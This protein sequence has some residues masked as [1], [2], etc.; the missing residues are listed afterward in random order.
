MVLNI[1]KIIHIISAI[2]W[3]AGLFYLPRIFVY[4]TYEDKGSKTS[5]TFKIMEHKL[6]SII[7]TPAMIS[8]WIMG[9]SMV[10]E[11]GLFFKYSFYIK[12]LSVILMTAYHYYL[13]YHLEQF[14]LD[15]NTKNH[16]YF[17]YLN[18]IPTVLIIVIITIVVLKP[19]NSIR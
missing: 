16:K 5:E 4:H 11:G 12:F 19:Y 14:K 3:M 10:I 18:E 13:G 6:Y 9:I 1:I 15:K 2:S 7:M 8:T 17:R